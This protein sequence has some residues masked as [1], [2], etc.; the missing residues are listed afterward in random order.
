MPTPIGAPIQG[1]SASQASP[2]NITHDSG[3][4][5]TN[6]T[7]IAIVF[8]YATSETVNAPTYGGNA[9]TAGPTV[10]T[11]NTTGV[12]RT[13]T[14]A[15]PPNGSNTLAITASG[16]VDELYCHVFSY[17]EV[18]QAT[19]WGTQQTNTVTGGTS[20]TIPTLTL[21]ASGISIGATF[22]YSGGV[23]TITESDTLILETHG[24]GSNSGRA[25]QV[26]DANLGWTFN[27]NTDMLGIGIP[28]NHS[29]GGASGAPR[30]QA[31]NRMMWNN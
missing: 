21:G 6:K 24:S 29:A 19:P 4:D 25:T 2:L 17:Y 28:L 3:A 26:G 27:T 12:I 5:Q 20:L 31:F 11:L 10:G 30:F 1:G 22:G 7:T 14:L 15:D 23:F 16:T 9:M 8:A 13:Y 18:D